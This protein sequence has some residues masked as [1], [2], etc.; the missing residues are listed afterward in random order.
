MRYMSHSSIHLS[1][2]GETNME[3]GF[4]SVLKVSTFVAFQEVPSD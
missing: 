3:C 1:E 2:A 4:G